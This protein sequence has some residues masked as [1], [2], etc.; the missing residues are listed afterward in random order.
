MSDLRGRGRNSIVEQPG[1]IAVRPMHLVEATALL[2]AACSRRCSAD[3]DGSVVGRTLSA[4]KE[5]RQSPGP[6]VVVHCRSLL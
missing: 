5:E 2:R 6:K 1:T 3:R 4:E